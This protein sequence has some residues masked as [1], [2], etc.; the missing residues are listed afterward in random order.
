MRSLASVQIISDI[1]PIEG[2]DRIELV[3]ILGWQCVANKGTFN[4]GDKCIYFEIDS[5]LPVCDR[6]EFL[7]KSSYKNNEIMGE[8]FR[9]KTMTLRGEI[10]QGLALPLSDF[11]ELKNVEVGQDVTGQLHV[12]KW[13]MPEVSIG[14]EILI[15]SKPDFIGR[16]DE[17]RIQSIPEVLNEFK[18]LDYYITT[19][20][21]GTSRCIG[22]N[23]TGDFYCTSQSNTIKESMF[24]D[25]V[26]ENNYEELLRNYMKEKNLNSIVVAGEWCGYGIQKNKLQ[27]K[28]PC[29]YIFTVKENGKRVSYDELCTVVKALSANM[30]MVDE[31][32]TDLPTKY[33]TIEAL[34]EK[35]HGFYPNGGVREGIVI[36]PLKPVY[37]KTLNGPLSIKVINNKYLLKN[38]D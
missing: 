21:D 37:S 10:S 4:K 38:K 8:G 11:P 1:V 16:T 18:G 12:K 29:W 13:D 35:A 5:F 23:E 25:Y 22:I 33:P 28:K 7:R 19:K 17:T 24:V 2:A 27:L 20:C 15:N 31:I 9:V 3:K 32:G 34:L 36:R 30:V 14:N 6:F 26:K